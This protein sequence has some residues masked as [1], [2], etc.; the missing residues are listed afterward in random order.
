MTLTRVWVVL[1]LRSN[2]VEDA[3]SLRKGAN[4]VEERPE[5]RK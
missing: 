4:H 2:A 5:F 3:V 1:R